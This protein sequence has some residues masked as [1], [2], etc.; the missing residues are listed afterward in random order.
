[1]RPRSRV[2]DSHTPPCGFEATKE[3]RPQGYLVLGVLPSRWP[4]RGPVNA[5][6]GLGRTSSELIF[7]AFFPHLRSGV[8]VLTSSFVLHSE[9]IFRATPSSQPKRHQPS[10]CSPCRSIPTP[11]RPSQCRPRQGITPTTAQAAPSAARRTQTRTGPR[12]HISLS[13][14][15]YR[16]ASPSATTVRN[17]LGPRSLV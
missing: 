11:T 16:T 14:G 4:R 9:L 5:V 6:L 15:G 10:P 1:M 17:T 8:L 7:F 13:A 2:L 12:F 3:R